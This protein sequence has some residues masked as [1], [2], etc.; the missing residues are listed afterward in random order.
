M[1]NISAITISGI[2]VVTVWLWLRHSL[3]NHRLTCLQYFS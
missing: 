2:M 3:G 1:D